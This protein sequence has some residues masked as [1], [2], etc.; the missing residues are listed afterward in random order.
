MAEKTTE[1]TINY[2]LS[3]YGDHYVITPRCYFDAKPGKARVKLNTELGCVSVTPKKKPKL[4]SQDYPCNT[5][6]MI[7]G[8]VIYLPK[9][10]DLTQDIEIAHDGPAK[11]ILLIKVKKQPEA[12]AAS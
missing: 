2:T 5:S 7:F 3:D 10:A 4:T 9:K 12:A 8:G 1:S 11:Q 6:K